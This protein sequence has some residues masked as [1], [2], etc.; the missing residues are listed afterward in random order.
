[1]LTF[2]TLFAIDA[3]RVDVQSPRINETL[4]ALAEPT[5]DALAQREGTGR[6]ARTP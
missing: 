2:T 6:M 3:A 1:M 4:G 5:A